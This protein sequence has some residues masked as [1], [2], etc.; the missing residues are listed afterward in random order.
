MNAVAAPFPGI[1]DAASSAWSRITSTAAGAWSGLQSM[2]QRTG[3]SMKAPFAGLA[4]AASSAWNQVRT[5][6]S[7]AWEAVESRVA[8]LARTAAQSANAVRANAAGGS[9]LLERYTRFLD[10][11]NP[12]ERELG[13]AC[14]LTFMA[15]CDEVWV[16][17][18]DG[19]SSGM[20]QEL[21]H[22]F[23]LGKR[24]VEIK[25]V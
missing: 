6:A 20:G 3:Q 12:S 1:A 4:T 22:A 21:D 23:R 16:Y 11:R 24:V 10:D 13:I 15:V 18:A 5:S 19:V 2:A 9:T 7:G 8:G 25:E 14:G 17:T